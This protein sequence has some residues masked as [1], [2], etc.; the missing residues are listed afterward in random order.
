MKKTKLIKWTDI[1]KFNKNKILI[2]FYKKHVKLKDIE[3]L[4][5]E[6]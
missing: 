1:I 2:P 5:V 6:G 3:R 4:K